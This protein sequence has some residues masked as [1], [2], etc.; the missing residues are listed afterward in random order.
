MKKVYKLENL[1]CANCAAKMENAIK[2]ID[3][4]KGASI[5]FMTQKLTIEVEDSL[6]NDALKKAAKHVKELIPIVRSVCDTEAICLINKNK[7]YSGW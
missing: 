4:V 6:F 1:N 3:G 5:S 2:K 7:I